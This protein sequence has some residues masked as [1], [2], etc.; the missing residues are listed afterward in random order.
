M[1]KLTSILLFATLPFS[2]SACGGAPG[3]AGPTPE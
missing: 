1:K 2:L 3:G